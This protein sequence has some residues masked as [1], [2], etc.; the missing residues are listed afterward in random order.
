MN[1][2]LTEF[3]LFSRIRAVKLHQ[4]LLKVRY[5]Q[6]L[7]LFH[8]VKFSNKKKTCVRAARKFSP[9]VISKT[10]F[11]FN[12]FGEHL[13]SLRVTLSYHLMR[14]L[15]FLS[16]Q[17]L[18]SQWTPANHVV[19]TILQTVHK[20]AYLCSFQDSF[21]NWSS[22]LYHP[23]GFFFMKTIKARHVK[24]NHAYY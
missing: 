9:T 13:G 8:Q 15:H 14:L 20:F 17:Q 3:N 11:C 19:L 7:V 6:L 21:H 18:P 1:P 23:N 5:W 22:S 2:M 12:F 16:V 4:N 10:F 24:W